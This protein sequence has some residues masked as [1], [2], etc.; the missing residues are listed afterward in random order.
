LETCTTQVQEKHISSATDQ[1]LKL[2]S[3]RTDIN[4]STCREKGMWQTNY[5]L[6]Q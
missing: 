2:K 4:K 1:G 3:N 6:D 5:I